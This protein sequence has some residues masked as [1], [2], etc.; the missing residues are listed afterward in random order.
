MSD[1]PVI[2][3]SYSHKDEPEKPV[4][5]E[6]KWLTFVTD[7][8]KLGVKHGIYDLWFD[9]H[10]P[11][12]AD[13][14][15]EIERKVRACD[16][17]ILLVS[18]NS[19]ASDYIIDKEIPIVRD[20]QMKR[21]PVH[22]YPLLVSPTP[23]PGLEK[24]KDKNLRPRGA[25]PLSSYSFYDRAQ[26]MTDTANEIAQLVQG[27]AKEKGTVET[28][29]VRG[30]AGYV[31]IAGLPET[32]YRRL[33]GRETEL[34]R[35][36]SAW[37]DREINIISLIAEGGAGKSALVNE[38]LKKLQAEKYR[39]AEIVLGWSFYSQG[40]KER[41][42]SSEGFLNWMLG[43]LRIGIDSPSALAKA[44]IIADELGKRRILLVLD[45]LEPLQHGPGPQEGQLKDQALRALLRRVATVSSNRRRGLIVVTS[46]LAVKD[47]DRWRDNA[48]P[49]V[50][51]EQ[52]SDEAGAALLSDSGVQGTYRELVT[53]AHE[54]GGHPLGLALL[55]TFLVEKYSGD[56]RRR[57]H[58]RAFFGDAENPRHDHAK[59]VMESYEAE[60]LA[61]QPVMRAI[62]NMVGL[63]DRPATD[64]CLRALGKEP[65]IIGLTDS[66]V[67]LDEGRW[68][69]AVNR[70]REVH[71]LAPADPSMPGALDAHPLVREWFGERLKEKSEK[72]WREAHGR[73]YE[74]LRDTTHE[75]SEPTLEDLSP[76]YQAIA[77]GCRAGRHEETLDEI[78]KDRICRRESGGKVA[79]H[80]MKKLGA[81][82]SDL[83]AMAW[84]FDDP[85]AM[86]STNIGSA[87]RSWVLG[88]AAF[89]LRAQ[90][91]FDEALLALLAT[92]R[93]EEHRKNW[94][95][96]AI[97]ACNLSETQLLVGEIVAAIASAA[98]SVD[99]AD[100][101]GDEFDMMDH[102]TLHAAALHA[103]GQDE[104][105]SHLFA[106]AQQRQHARDPE[107]PLL[108]S[109]AGYREW[110]LL[111]TQGNFA[112]VRERA[113]RALE[114]SRSVL[115][116]LTVAL[117]TLAIGR[118]FLGLAHSNVNAQRLSTSDEIR[119]ARA[120]LDS[121]V[122][123]LRAAGT[124]HHIPRGLLARTAFHRS[125]GDWPS[126]AGD[127]DE[128]EEIAEPGPMRLYL[129]DI[130]LERSRLA[131]AQ[132]EAFAPLNGMLEDN[133]PKPEVPSEEKIAELKAEAEKQIK[134]ADDYIQ[135]C[136]YHRRDEELAELKE[137]L[138]GKKT[139]ASLPPRV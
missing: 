40:S 88:M 26:H 114:W 9:R 94:S 113:S 76:L 38:W 14:N 52:L 132:V 32:A 97:A 62:M 4:D 101:G 127:L 119:T 86:P 73:L 65:V 55:A 60:W 29:E 115:S 59:R 48:A 100:R 31:H 54:F 71:L 30:Q 125:I 130:A 46:R 50:D 138:A 82:G 90:G 124:N 121:A 49:V 80:S 22:F 105:A 95:N 47:I 23:E 134:I 25:K 123:R 20:R 15:P 36:D 24:V 68:Q 87:E 139:F 70:L 43:A 106:D 102:R 135:K 109:V 112:V 79:F 10:M 61:D 72:A 1:K 98:R 117:N 19:M 85:Y 120:D 2:F 11:G 128:V 33:V 92:M 103:A 41:A 51:I 84:F 8:L 122:D 5:G 35:L 66:I 104:K 7:Y 16:I 44:E 129:C 81:L 6:V 18:A 111:M 67:G 89:A 78:Y 77:H 136:G 99:L 116:L 126:A 74:H 21:E 13:W 64:D 28:T 96:A 69:R 12:G 53:A 27:I 58:I 75:G 57:D 131:F 118:A 3:I 17:F 107:H 63:F 133:P 56:I 45:G 37:A 93:M 91:R 42:T 83:A 108:H 137:V 39:D 110:D 34:L